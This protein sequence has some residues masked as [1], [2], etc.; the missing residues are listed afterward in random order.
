MKLAIHF[1]KKKMFCFFLAAVAW[2]NLFNKFVLYKKN[3]FWTPYPA[4][5]IFALFLRN[6]GESGQFSN[7]CLKK[8]FRLELCIKIK[9]DGGRGRGAQIN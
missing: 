3:I 1:E 9:I 7:F 2:F 5:F 6:D 8:Y 4:P